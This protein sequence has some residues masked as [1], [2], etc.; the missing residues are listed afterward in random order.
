MHSQTRQ[1]PPTLGLLG[2]IRYTHVYP[3]ESGSVPR[4]R[5][6]FRAAAQDSKLDPDLTDRIELCL[7]ELAANSVRHARDRRRAPKFQV[8]CAIRR[9]RRRYHLEVA[10]WDIDMWHVPDLPDPDT[11]AVRLFN[12]LDQDAV[13]GRGLLLVAMQADELGYDLGPHG[14]RLWSRW[15]L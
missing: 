15:A 4:A 14:K 6:H 11:A 2:N 5:E 9:L 3:L 7:T 10:V 8:Q 1:G 13:S 12:M